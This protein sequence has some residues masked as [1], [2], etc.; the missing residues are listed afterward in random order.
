M[1]NWRYAHCR[2]CGRH[3]DEVGELSKRGRCADCAWTRHVTEVTELREQRGPY[4]AYWAFK[5][6]ESVGMAPLDWTPD[7]P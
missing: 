6:A 5:I 2:H 4:A 3:R 7:R 1:A